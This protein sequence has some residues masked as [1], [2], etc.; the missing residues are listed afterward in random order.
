MPAW[1][2]I[3][4]DDVADYMVAAKL[5]ALRT[6]ALAAGQSDPVVAAI[7]D[8]VQRI[9]LEVQA[10]RSNRLSATAGTIPPELR[11]DAIALIV[12]AATR[13][14]Q[15]TIGEDERKA[16]DNA[17]TFLRRIATCEVPISQPDDPEGEPQIQS[18]GGAAVVKPTRN[19]FDREAMNGL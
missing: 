10:C 13:R 19:R 9:R 5:T 15:G 3:T 16:A 6:K 7:A 11:S 2:T 14:L 4:V 8:V 18:K 17:R 12:E 1:I